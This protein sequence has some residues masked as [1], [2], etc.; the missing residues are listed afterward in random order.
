MGHSNK[1]PKNA[2]L[3]SKMTNIHLPQLKI[4]AIGFKNLNKL[5]VN[6]ISNI[7]QILFTHSVGLQFWVN[8]KPYTNQPFGPSHLPYT[9]GVSGKTDFIDQKTSIQ[10]LRPGYHTTIHV[11]PKILGT[12]SD[13]DKFEVD[14]RGCKLPQE[15]WGFKF[16]KKYSRKGCELECAMRK[17]TSYCKC[18]PWQYPNNFT[19]MPMCDMFGGYCFNQIMSNIIYYKTC[20]TECLEDCHYTSLSMWHTSVPL[21]THE[22][23]KDGTQ[24]DKFF[25]HHFQRFF[26]F[27]NYQMMIKKK[28]TFDLEKSLS[29]GSL[30]EKYVNQYVSFVSIESPTKIVTKSHRDQRKFF[31]DKL[32]T[33]GGTLGVCA[34][35]SV[36]SMVEVGVFVYIVL[37]GMALDM[38]HLWKRLISY[39]KKVSTTEKKSKIPNHAKKSFSLD[40]KEDQ[41]EV[42]KLCVSSTLALLLYSH[43][44]WNDPF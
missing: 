11:I 27:E 16:L 29:N 5:C 21:E 41:Q 13:F 20:K 6:L 15:T 40:F 36:L 24:F 44:G 30:C 25:R 18:L 19:S 1:T 8:M 32:G 3:L 37:L 7:K 35:M 33:I 43:S 14:T 9:V 26:A 4:L 12:T 31:I 42:Q 23:C 2:D 38:R 17:A 10:K 28:S 22:I 39:K 34:G